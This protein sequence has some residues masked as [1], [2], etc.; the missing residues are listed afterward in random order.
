[1]KW[2]ALLL[3]AGAVSTVRAE[4]VMICYNYG[5]RKSVV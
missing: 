2:L 5:D 3:L 4:A 1:M